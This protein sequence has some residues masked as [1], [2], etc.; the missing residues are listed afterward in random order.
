MSLVIRCSSCSINLQCS[1]LSSSQRNNKTQS[2]RVGE[3]MRTGI[4]YERNEPCLPCPP[5]PPPL[6]Y[7]SPFSEILSQDS[8]P[9]KAKTTLVFQRCRPTTSLRPLRLIN[10]CVMAQFVKVP[11][12][13]Y[14]HL[15]SHPGLDCPCGAAA[16]RR[17]IGSPSSSSPAT[18]ARPPACFLHI[19][20]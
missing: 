16:G 10:Y 14:G 5:F 2:T 18:P 6:P 11:Q 7:L 17:F 1:L 8:P 19:V 20:C 13:G 12:G 3:S 4:T 15:E 9:A